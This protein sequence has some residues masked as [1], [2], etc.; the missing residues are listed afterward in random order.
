[1]LCDDP[2]EESVCAVE[3]LVTSAGD[4]ELADGLELAVFTERTDEGY[5]EEGFILE[6]IVLEEVPGDRSVCESEEA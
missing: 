1:M 4:I 3:G 2:V 5:T 6:P